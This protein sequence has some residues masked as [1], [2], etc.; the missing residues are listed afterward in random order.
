MFVD[1][2]AFGK[3]L[4]I[5]RGAKQLHEGRVGGSGEVGF[6]FLGGWG[7]RVLVSFLIPLLFFSSYGFRVFL[8]SG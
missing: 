2:V 8:F 4:G 7:R 6:R 5:R 3:N 1:G